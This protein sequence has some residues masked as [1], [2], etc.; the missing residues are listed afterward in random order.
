MNADKLPPHRSYDHRIPLNEGAVP[1]H[2]RI[3]RLSEVELMAL[4]D[5]ID[6]NLEKGFIRPSESP[7]G[8][9]ILFVKKKDSSLRLC[10]DYR[11]LDSKTIKN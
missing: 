8:C 2:G 4:R 6:E 11:D 1:S 7:A 3:Y 9:P 10:V 5:Y